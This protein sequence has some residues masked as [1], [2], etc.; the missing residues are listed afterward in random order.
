M[1]PVRGLAG[2]S[3]ARLVCLRSNA[4]VYDAVGGLF[5][6]NF[7][8]TC[9]GSIDR[10]FISLYDALCNSGDL[11]EVVR[12]SAHR[13]R[14]AQPC[15]APAGGAGEGISF[16]IAL[17]IATVVGCIGVIGWSVFAGSP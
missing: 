15:P 10:E 12:I 9:I 16:E 2:T 8:D 4:I 14:A 17:L 6:S 1:G 3:I 5:G 13:A 11:M 7:V